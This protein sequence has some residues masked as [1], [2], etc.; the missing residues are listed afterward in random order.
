MADPQ[1][2]RFDDAADDFDT[3]APSGLAG[4]E[5]LQL[6]PEDT[7][8]EESISDWAL[9][10]KVRALGL[11]VARESDRYNIELFDG[12]RENTYQDQRKIPAVDAVRRAG[13]APLNGPSFTI[14]ELQPDGSSKPVKVLVTEIREGSTKAHLFFYRGYWHLWS[15]ASAHALDAGGRDGRENAFTTI[16]IRVIRQ[17]RPKCLF[18][19]NL[20]RLVRRME[21]GSRLTCHLMTNV[22]H[23][24]VKEMKF[25]LVGPYGSIGLIFLNMLT[26]VAAMERD[27]IMMRLTAGRVSRWRRGEW[28]FG[29]QIVP[30]G[31]KLIDGHL[32]PDVTKR[33]IIREMLLLLSTDLPDAAMQQALGELGV[34]AMRTEVGSDTSVPFGAL[35]HAASA[36]SALYAWAGLWVT[37][38][39]LLRHSNPIPGAEEVAGIAVTRYETADG[40]PDP[41]DH[42]ELQM[43]HQVELPED[44]WAE[45]EVLNAFLSRARARTRDLISRGRNRTRPLSDAVVDASHDPAVLADILP[46]LW[47]VGHDKASSAS[48]DSARARSVISALSGRTWEDDEEGTFELQ[49]RRTGVYDLI[50]WPPTNQPVTVESKK[51]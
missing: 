10:P 9:K 1:M 16:L 47:A 43:L 26:W 19:A 21:Q 44:G 7:F 35:T 38:E 34:T 24:Y 22:D 33:P 25:D 3:T 5:V 2:H 50:Y 49:V 27:A 15:R 28:A 6:L 39:Y 30:F 37:G 40:E 31:Y 8:E 48:R 51:D 41:E 14:A 17:L 12:L 18:A 11:F 29:D 46:N 45:P 36:I 20:S 23:V 13:L 32:K 42:G 4:A